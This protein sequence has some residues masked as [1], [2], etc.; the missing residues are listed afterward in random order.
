MKGARARVK[1]GG[2]GRNACAVRHTHS[3]LR[4][5]DPSWQVL[6]EEFVKFGPIASVKIMWPRSDEEKSRA[7]MSGFVAFMTRKSA[8]DA[9]DEMNG[10]QPRTSCRPSGDG[11]VAAVICSNARCALLLLSCVWDAAALAIV[12]A[13]TAAFA[14]CALRRGSRVNLA[15]MCRLTRSLWAARFRA[16]RLLQNADMRIGWGKSITIPNFPIYPPPKQARSPTLLLRP[17]CCQPFCSAAANT[18]RCG[19]TPC[20]GWPRL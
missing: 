8:E 1:F 14:A 19:A 7:R 10:A 4:N 16:G 11:N 15:G 2:L 17:S 12:G 20:T 6:L 9:R 3:S 13:G 18:E 5:G